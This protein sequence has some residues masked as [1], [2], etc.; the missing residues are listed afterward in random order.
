MLS[1][2][3]FSLQ[4]RLIVGFALILA[5]AL[6]SVSV[7]LGLVA[8]REVDRIQREVD[9][10]RANRVTQILSQS[11]AANKAWGGIQTIITRAGFLSEREIL[12]LD[13]NGEVVGHSDERSRGPT[14]LS[15]RRRSKMIP[16]TL[17][18]RKVGS[19]IVG[20]GAIRPSGSPRLDVADITLPPGAQGSFDEPSLARFA[21]AMNRSLLWA[22]LAA[23]AGGILLVSFL[24]RR[25]LAPAKALS[26][27]AQALRSGDLGQRV[28]APGRDDIGELGSSFNAMAESLEDAERQRRNMV[29]DVAHELRSPLSNI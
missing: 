27:A 18:R 26:L 8:H 20:F 14:G 12:V 21:Q 4:F 11:S 22:G 3:F 15:K 2:W 24:S 25:M 10:A 9:E 13:E 6:G 16:I 5:L 19:V 7:Y 28:P 29:A 23:G 1:K 17:D